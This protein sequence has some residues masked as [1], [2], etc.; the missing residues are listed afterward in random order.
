MHWETY[1]KGVKGI[2]PMMRWN[3]EK[4]TPIMKMQMA[5]NRI[6]RTQIAHNIGRTNQKRLRREVNMQEIQKWSDGFQFER[7]FPGFEDHEIRNEVIERFETRRI[8]TL[9]RAQ[10]IGR[11]GEINVKGMEIFSMGSKKT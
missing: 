2:S 6:W 4:V 10:K 5:R 11:G 1:K 3:N 8:R 9:I 7:Y